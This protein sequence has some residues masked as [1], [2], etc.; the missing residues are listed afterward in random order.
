MTPESRKSGI[1]TIIT[2]QRL[3]KH[4][5]AATNSKIEL[6][7]AAFSMGSVPMLLGNGCVNTFPQQQIH[8]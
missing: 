5:T 3:G 2:R 8:T 6:L 4:V 1:K 7:E